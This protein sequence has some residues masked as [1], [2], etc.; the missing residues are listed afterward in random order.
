MAD[1]YWKRLHRLLVEAAE[2]SLALR[3]SFFGGGGKEGD[4]GDENVARRVACDLQGLRHAQANDI[5]AS[6][7]GDSRYID[8]Y[9]SRAAGA[10]VS[11]GIADEHANWVAACLADVEASREKPENG[12]GIVDGME[13]HPDG[14]VEDVRV[15]VFEA[16]ISCMPVVVGT[17]LIDVR[18]IMRRTKQRVDLCVKILMALNGLRRCTQASL[19]KMKL[20]LEKADLTACVDRE[21]VVA[22]KEKERVKSEK[23]KSI[24]KSGG[25]TKRKRQLNAAATFMKRFVKA[26][27]MDEAR[28]L[29][30]LPLPEG[31]DGV[32]APVADDR[33]VMS[34]AW[35]LRSEMDVLPSEM[36]ESGMRGDGNA[37][38]LN[39]VLQ[40]CASRRSIAEGRVP[41]ALGEYRR[42][43]KVNVEDRTPRFVK[44][45]A[46]VRG[47]GKNGAVK[48]LQFDENN[49]PAYY[50]T[51][52]KRSR[53]V[54]G[55]RPLAKEAGLDYEADSDDEWEE[56]GE[57]LCDVEAE[58][59]MA[60]ED[61]E[62]KRLY[63]SDDEEDDDFLDDGDAE[64]EDDEGEDE[65]GDADGDDNSPANQE[66][67][68]GA[69]PGEGAKRE[70]GGVVDLTMVTVKSPVK[71]GKRAGRDENGK[72]VKR[73]RTLRQVVVIHHA[74]VANTDPT[75]LDKHPVTIFEDAQPIQMFNPF[76]YNTSDIAAEHLK[77][78]P[79]TVR[80]TRPSTM[81]DNAKLDLALTLKSGISSKDRIVLQF[82]EQR[83]TRGLRV[84]SKS[85]ILRAIDEIGTREKRD[86]DTRAGWYLNDPRLAL[87]LE[88]RDSGVQCM[89][90]V[91][92]A[93]ASVVKAE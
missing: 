69:K 81:D 6:R 30:G 20:Q 76:V 91:V 58:K 9:V 16:E 42:A 8:T 38:D 12:V 24:G 10:F 4:G 62:L 79:P 43:R 83:K 25:K 1:S 53:T 17:E 21:R 74:S 86:G 92:S 35:W 23:A 59:D 3:G 5:L 90:T 80:V 33:E 32:V 67:G 40:F 51:Y 15:R 71:N 45:R 75:R 47:R 55:R 49:R 29:P 46:Q 77:A 78:K 73:R 70:D 11:Y 89:P 2:S 37:K 85:E 18:K 63:G 34:V 19:E 60:L 82:C 14:A 61:A 64:D 56:E 50:G 27:E 28:D 87:K 48:L 88:S 36:V 72:K 52:G 93:S 41:D 84:P 13:G 65:D 66:A 57:D 31:R 7:E 54:R 22:K 26:K 44:R 39:S 68:E